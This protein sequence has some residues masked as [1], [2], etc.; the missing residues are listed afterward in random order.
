LTVRFQA[1]NDL[2]FGILKAVRRREP[3]IDFASAQEAG[4][5][6]VGDP[7]L[8]DRA[9]AEGRVLVSHDRRTMIAHFR[10]HLAAGKSAPGL[11]IVS[12]GALI[13]EAVEALVY[14]W[15]LSNPADLRDQAYYLPSLSRH[16]FPR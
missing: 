14:V 13:G 10:A 3:A 8:L 2:K 12:Q 4:L 9:A 11:L 6:E 7:E 5:D 16:F 15:A 1:D